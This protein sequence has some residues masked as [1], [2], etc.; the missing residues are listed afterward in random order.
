MGWLSH[1]GQVVEGLYHV[2]LD[3]DLK[4]DQLLSQLVLR[5]PAQLQHL[6]VRSANHTECLISFRPI[7]TGCCVLF[8]VSFKGLLEMQH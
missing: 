4:L 1:L 7:R 2:P 8:S 3:G 5:L 6:P